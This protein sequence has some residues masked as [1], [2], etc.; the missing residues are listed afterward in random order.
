MYRV[1]PIQPEDLD[2][3]FELYAA[4]AQFQREKRGG[5]VARI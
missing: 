3:V 2:M 1:A 4:A 5:G